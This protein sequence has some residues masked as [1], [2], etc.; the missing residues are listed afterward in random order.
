M[1]RRPCGL[2]SVRRKGCTCGVLIE[3][4]S[5]H[6]THLQSAGTEQAALPEKAPVMT[7]DPRIQF[8]EISVRATEF[9][10][11]LSDPGLLRSGEMPPRAT[12]EIR[13]QQI[14]RLR[15]NILL[16]TAKREEFNRKMDEYI[17]NLKAL[18]RSLEKNISRE[19]KGGAQDAAATGEHSTLVR[20]LKCDSQRLFKEMQIVFARESDESL[21]LPTEVYVL[22]G[23][24]LKKGL[25]LCDACGPG[26]MVIRPL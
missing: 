14:A 8:Q 9:F 2:D 16:L 4:H 1:A 7:P 21:C 6:H 18:I 3:R 24:A 15:E 19:L 12:L 17:E 20:C 22:E 5:P 11:E 26:N 23:S 10:H 25:F 13:K